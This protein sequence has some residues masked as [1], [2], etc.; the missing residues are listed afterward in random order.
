ME[1]NP[2]P[3]SIREYRIVCLAKEGMS[4]KEI[5]SQLNIEESTVKCHRRNVM[6]KLGLKGKVEFLRFL[7]NVPQ[8]L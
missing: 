4:N 6:R 3:L 1:F 2:A 7:L 5:A 8:Q